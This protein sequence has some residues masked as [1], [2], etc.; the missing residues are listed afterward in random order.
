MSD[1]SYYSPKP[2]KNN[3][4]VP[5]AP[6]KKQKIQFCSNL[7]RLK[8]SGTRVRNTLAAMPPNN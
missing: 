6:R 1:L 4:T 7:D 2:T 5:N 8:A 3:N